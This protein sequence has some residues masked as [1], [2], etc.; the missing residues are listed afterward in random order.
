MPS[1]VYWHSEA[2]TLLVWVF[3]GRW[4]LAEFDSAF[5]RWHELGTQAAH[6]F[7]G[8]FDLS[9]NT[10]MPP[11][12]MRHALLRFETH[13]LDQFAAAYLVVRDPFVRMLATAF[14]SLL[15]KRVPL[16]IFDS[17]EDAVQYASAH[18]PHF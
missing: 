16:H 4:T 2:H 18:P 9:G 14:T 3:T 6:P 17:L 7:A 12:I 5:A 13:W 8:V 11:N 1:S 15:R 10:M